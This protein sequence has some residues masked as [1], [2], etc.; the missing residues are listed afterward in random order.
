M[1]FG[2]EVKRRVR[3]ALPPLGFAALCGVVS[4]ESVT[5][6]IGARFPRAV[7]RGNIA[8]ATAA[9]DQ[10]LEALRAA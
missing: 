7:A 3:D 8:A 9:H 2:R 1:S 4:L 10:V 6:A 5:T